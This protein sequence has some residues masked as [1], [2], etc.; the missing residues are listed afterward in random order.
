MYTLLPE[1]FGDQYEDVARGVR[2][3]KAMAA[4]TAS[5]IARQCAERAAHDPEGEARRNDAAALAARMRNAF[6][7]GDLARVETLAHEAIARRHRWTHARPRARAR[8]RTTRRL[9]TR[10]SKS[11]SDDGPPRSPRRRI[12]GAP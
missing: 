8:R 2:V 7:R 1:T 4:R 5:W 6:R 9:A 12:G 10:G 3:H 11:S